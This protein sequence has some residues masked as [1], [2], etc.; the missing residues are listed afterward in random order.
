[1]SRL[2]SYILELSLAFHTSLKYAPSVVAASSM[3]L[4][5]YSLR[6]DDTLTLWPNELSNVTGLAL[7]DLAECAVQLSQDVENARLDTSRLKQIHRRHSKAC[8]QNAAELSIPVLTS[9]NSLTDYEERLRS[10]ISHS[11]I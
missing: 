1:M 2:C 7:K 11:N 3:V 8:R 10:R 9:K 6:N 5:Y 4:A